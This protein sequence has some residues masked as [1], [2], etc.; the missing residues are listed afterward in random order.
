MSRNDSDTRGGV[1]GVVDDDDDGANLAQTNERVAPI[2]LSTP[3]AMGGAAGTAFNVL[4]KE[5]SSQKHEDKTKKDHA[6]T[7]SGEAK[8]Q[9]D[10]KKPK[11]TQGRADAEFEGRL[12]AKVLAS[13]VGACPTGGSLGTEQGDQKTKGGKNSAEADFEGRLHAKVLASSVQ[14]EEDQKAGDSVEGGA[15]LYLKLDDEAAKKTLQGGFNKTEDCAGITGHTTKRGSKTGFKGRPMGNV[16]LAAASNDRPLPLQMK[17]GEHDDSLSKADYIFAKEPGTLARAITGNEKMASRNVELASGS[18]EHPLPPQMQF[19]EHDDSLLNVKKKA[20]ENVELSPTSSEC[21]LPPQ[22]TF[23]AHDDSLS[24]AGSYPKGPSKVAGAVDDETFQSSKVSES[25]IRTFDD[26]MNEKVARR[27]ADTGD[28]RNNARLNSTEQVE[29]N[30]VDAGTVIRPLISTDNTQAQADRAGESDIESNIRR[31]PTQSMER[32]PSAIIIPEAYVVEHRDSERRDGNA[33]IDAYAEPLPPFWRQTRVK[34]LLAAIFV[35]V[36]LSAIGVGVPAGMRKKPLVMAATASPTLSLMP[37]P[38]PTTCKDSL[39]NSIMRL[40]LDFLNPSYVKVAVDGMNMVVTIIDKESKSL[41]VIF[42]MLG[43]DEWE[44][45]N[46]F[47]EDMGGSE[48]VDLFGEDNTYGV[49]NYNVA[50]SGA[51]ALVGPDEKNELLAYK[52]NHLGLWEKT[53]STIYYA[54]GIGYSFDIDGDLLVAAVITEVQYDYGAPKPETVQ[55]QESVQVYKRKNKRWEPIGGTIDTPGVEEILISGNTIVVKGVQLYFYK[56]DNA[57]DRVEVLQEPFGG[58]FWPCDGSALALSEYHL[59]YSECHEYSNNNQ[60]ILYH[61]QNTNQPFTLLREFEASQYGEGFGSSLAIDQ[62]ILVV[63]GGGRTMIFSLDSDIW[64][65][66]LTVDAREIDRS[67][68][69]QQISYRSILA[70]TADAGVYSIG[71]NACVPMQS[72]PPVPEQMMR[73]REVLKKLEPLSGNV[74]KVQGSFQNVAAKWISVE[75]AIQ[76]DVDDPRFE[77]R[78]IMALFYFAMD[79]ANWNQDDSWLSEKSECEWFGVKGDSVGCSGGCIKAG[80]LVG[81]YDR[82]CRIGMGTFVNFYGEIPSELGH[83]TEMRWFE[84]QDEY[85]IGT[86]PDSLGTGWK[87]LHTMLLDN[88]YLHGGFPDTF[89][90]NEMLG[91]IFLDHNRMNSTFPSVF[92]TLKNLEWLDVKNNQFN[93]T[94]PDDISNLKSLRIINVNNNN[95]S[96]HLPDAWDETNLIE[97]VEVSGNNFTGTLPPSLGGVKFLKDFAASRNKLTGTIPVTYYTLESLEELYLDENKLTGKLPQSAEPFYDGLQEFSIHSNSF[98][99]HF[100]VEQF[101]GIFRL[102]VLSLHNNNLEIVC[103][104]CTCYEDGQLVSLLTSPTVAPVG[105]G[106]DTSD[107]TIGNQYIWPTQGPSP[108]VIWVIQQQI[109]RNVLQRSVS[110]DKMEETDPRYLAMEWILSGD[111]MELSVDD[112]NLNQRYILAL[113]AFSFDSPSWYVCGD[114]DIAGEDCE[115]DFGQIGS[116]K[117]WLSSTD[118]C[119]WYGVICSDDGVVGVGLNQLHH[120]Q[121]LH[122]PH[123]CVYGTIPSELGKLAHL[124]SLELHGNGLSG[125]M[126]QEIYD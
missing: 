16:E 42:Y 25:I 54:P 35:V 28:G 49:V 101:E 81:D 79:G 60:V 8:G 96:G 114:H 119:E 39:L 111:Q 32:D 58:T 89:E 69:N 90:N 11:G 48:R 113:V 91:T 107:P 26:R 80:D 38:S 99:G 23:S 116:Y 85:L 125:E 123:N 86:I 30:S 5:P 122:L 43:D 109:E 72:S 75:D 67:F 47:V 77:Q 62:D 19:S 52:Q 9:G 94:L 59:A 57:A 6:G 34:M 29:N 46:L 64:E 40:D 117:V 68:V 44:R 98:S 14:N 65:E 76:L 108:S 2:G 13:S 103:K 41:Y 4:G 55:V 126:P 53:G 105:I 70:I 33:V 22:V 88:N 84:M 51:T 104:C 93:G 36:G 1:D 50:L 71:I 74:L 120:L 3:Q 106:T 12:L 66:L 92:S 27:V 45:V 83:L 95:M 100:P 73:Y 124:L 121:F 31:G 21:P 7:L 61:R 24:K 82:V 87:K 115:V 118:E 112:T 56:Y 17:F 97:D 37:S 20:S 15:T 102:K 63:G 10:Q 18:N 110:F 78:Y